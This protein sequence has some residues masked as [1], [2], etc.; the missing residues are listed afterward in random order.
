[1]T[2]VPNDLSLLIRTACVLEAS[3]RK[4]GNVHPLA[5]F[6][7]LCYE[8]FLNAAEA[9]SPV[10]A[11]SRELGVGRAVLDAV[12][13]TRERTS[14]NVNLGIIL[15]LAPL[16]A[17]PPG[18][19]LRDGIRDVLARLTNDDARLV[20]EA[21]RLAQ[22]GGLGRVDRE[23]VSTEPT[24]TLLDV[25]RLAADRD[26]IA[27]QYAMEFSLV[28]NDGVELLQ[29]FASD[30][31]QRWEQAIIHLQMT[32]LI[33][34]QD[35]LITRKCGRAE[36]REVQRSAFLADLF[37]QEFRITQRTFPGVLPT[38]SQPFDYWRVRGIREFDFWL[39]S[40][41]HRRNPGTTADL[42]AASLFAAFRDGIVPMPSLDDIYNEV[43]LW[44]P[45]DT[46]SA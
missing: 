14:S 38:T 42:I 30:F 39:R 16:A 45:N 24:G 1:M 2:P 15:L 32:L 6:P 25:M 3:A 8:D 28:V 27:K 13:A 21:I 22:P 17:V 18:V 37:V 5:S 40:D 9:A 19:P 44:G 20:Y 46:T 26:L 7:D 11:R 10:L 29:L 36:A 4:L 41:G 35:S 12:V 23:D 31:A 33:R 34:F 43:R